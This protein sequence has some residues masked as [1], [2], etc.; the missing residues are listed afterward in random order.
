VNLTDQYVQRCDTPSDI[1]DHL[2]FLY[3]QACRFP[4]ATILELGTRGGNSTAAFMAAAEQ[5]DG[6]VY[7][8]DIANPRVPEWWDE[9]PLWSLHIGDDL[10]PAA[11]DFA[12]ADVDVLFIDTSHGYEQTLAELEVYMPR[13]TGVALFHDTELRLPE[14]FERGPEFPVARALDEFCE[15]HD[16]E[17]TNRPGCYGLGVI[18][19]S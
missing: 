18:E 3:D 10:A 15:R 14:G 11:L 9:L 8:V 12:P 16:L 5:V 19:V 17:W 7:S 2:P 4:G 13:C 1:V 6:H